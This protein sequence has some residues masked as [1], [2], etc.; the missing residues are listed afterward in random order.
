MGNE[1]ILDVI[2]DEEHPMESQVLA[3]EGKENKSAEELLELAEKE[4]D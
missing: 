3:V 1:E 2:I 4:S